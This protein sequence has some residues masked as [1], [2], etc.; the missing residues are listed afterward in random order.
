MTGGSLGA[1]RA[2]QAPV[3][4]QVS[5]LFGRDSIYLLLW[6]VQLLCAAALTPVITRLLGSGE[7]GIV[8]SGNAVM[9]VLF[10][11]GGFGL[12]TAIQREYEACGGGRNAATV[13]AVAI[14]GAA[15]VTAAAYGTTALWSRPLGLQGES[16]SLRLCVLWAGV[17]AVTGASLALLRSQDRL[18]AFA[19][20][21]LI[22]SVVAEA[23]S[24]G[25]I[26]WHRATAEDFLA[27]QLLAQIAATVLALALAPPRAARRSDLVMIL[28]AFR[29]ALPLVPAVLGTFVL[30]SADRLMVQAALGNDAVARYQVAY[31]IASMPMLLLSVLHSSW[32]PRFFALG[33]GPQRAAVLAASRDMLY[34]LMVPLVSGFAVGAPLI[35]R[36][37]AP[38]S[39]RPESLTLV[40]SL[41]VVT[42]LPFAAQLAIG[43]A[44]TLHGSTGGIATATVLAAV[45]NIGLN[46]L[47]IPGFGLPGSAAATLACYLLLYAILHAQGRRMAPVAPAGWPLRLRLMAA[48]TVALASAAAPTTGPACWARA[49]LVA[50]TAAWFGR[51]LLEANRGTA[52]AGSR[53]R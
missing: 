47:L 21:S 18:L 53:P 41:V 44:L 50:A 39:Y 29:F 8:A 19:A 16:A 9:Q 10:V 17:S 7:F 5:H 20:V 3:V 24:L 45:A 30:S 27:G 26:G 1:A 34:R 35:L 49:L 32:M 43:R 23:A 36:V 22:Q 12:Q 48:V 40:V 6:A 37:W 2:D 14:A 52:D 31:N 15:V 4:Q 25:L 46:L 51:I 28:G 11:I 38:P 33:E 42:A 13:L